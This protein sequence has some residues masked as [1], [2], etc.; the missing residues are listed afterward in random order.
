MGS[1]FY[2]ERVGKAQRS[3]HKSPLFDRAVAVEQEEAE[4]SVGKHSAVSVR[5]RQFPLSLAFACTIRKVQGLS[6]DKIV[7]SMDGSFKDGQAYVAMSRAKKLS[8]LFLLTLALKNITGSTQVK[9]E[10]ERLCKVKCAPP[11][12]M[13]SETFSDAWLKVCHINERSV[14]AHFKDLISDKR[15]MEADVIC[16]SE[17]C[18]STHVES[19]NIQIPGFNLL[20][21]DK[22][23]RDRF[24]QNNSTALSGKGGGAAVYIKTD[25]SFQE[26]PTGSIT[27]GNILPVIVSAS[28][29]DT[30]IL[31]GYN[32]KSPI[33]PGYVFRQRVQAVIQESHH[34][35]VLLVGDMNEDILQKQKRQVMD[36]YAQMGLVQVLERPT[37]QS[38]SLLD[39]IYLHFSEA[40]ETASLAVYGMFPAYFTDHN[41]TFTV[42][43][44]PGNEQERHLLTPIGSVEEKIRGVVEE[45]NLHH[46]TTMFDMNKTCQSVKGQIQ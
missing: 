38:G 10:M 14:V 24:T 6:L 29:Y 16:I 17:S 34:S 2:D 41:A 31:T 21:K 12:V 36:S 4:F 45:R 35:D 3:K 43:P 25:H 8:G 22:L 46:S 40:P 37:H 28:G 1:A 23:Q 9:K 15:L 18:L 42:L 33:T 32:V 7:V 26:V 5:M 39:P 11:L 20:R 44:T 27:G 30:M 13:L 19:T